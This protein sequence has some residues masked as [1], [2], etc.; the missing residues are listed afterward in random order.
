MK[1]AT[2]LVLSAVLLSACAE[3][4]QSMKCVGEM[5]FWTR[6]TADDPKFDTEDRPSQAISF[7][8]MF[9]RYTSWSKWN[10]FVPIEVAYLEKIRISKDSFG[11]YDYSY[12]S[13]ENSRVDIVFT[14]NEVSG[15][16]YYS[17]GGFDVGSAS[18]TVRANCKKIA[19]AI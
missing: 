1:T 3:T 12:V 15:A 2:V 17:I 19:N 8:A 7:Y 16:L 6:R 10:E 5:K 13:R 14:F 11:S 18:K 9:K 4:T